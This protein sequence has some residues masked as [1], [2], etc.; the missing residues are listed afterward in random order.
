MPDDVL[1]QKS[2]IIENCIH[3]IRDV[4]D[5]RPENLRDD[6]TKQDS[7]LLNLERA[8][9]AAID[10]AARLCRM[11]MLGIPKESR[12]SFTL[13]EKAGLLPSELAEKMRKM[14]GLRNVAVHAYQTLDLDLVE[15]VIQNHLVDF[16]SFVRFM[17]TR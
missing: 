7:I 10:G 9:Q 14:V 11:K 8:C 13:L 12:E 1:V 4:Y 6:F 3:R 5:Q 16:E 17:L 15:N 2:E